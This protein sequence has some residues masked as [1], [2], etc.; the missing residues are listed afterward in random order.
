MTCGIYYIRNS[1][2]GRLY[3]GS[4]ANVQERWK[5]HRRLLAR[6][7]HHAPILQKAWNKYGPGAFEFVLVEEC[8]KAELIAREQF[9]I[10][11]HQAYGKGYNALP[12]AGR[13]TSIPPAVRAK[14]S[15]SNR[16]LAARS[17]EL[18]ALRSEIARR[19]HAEGRLGQKSWKPGTSKIVGRK[20]WETRR[21]KAQEQ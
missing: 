16:A 17:P 10:D 6:G 12:E 19:L 3:V 15:A 1:R 9:H 14:M 11:L 7:V 5:N 2:N 4:S 21:A 8:Q 20:A 18:R 13:P